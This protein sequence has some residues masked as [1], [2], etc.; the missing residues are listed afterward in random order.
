MNS[1]FIY[2]CETWT[3][4]RYLQKIIRALEMRCLRRLLNI[5]YKD[6]VND[7]EFRRQVTCQLV[8][9]SELL[10]NVT[11]KKLKWFCHVTR[12]DTISKII[13]Q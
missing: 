5:K 10:A 8:P 11:E 6:R 7:V 2:A 1:I 13:L 9:H 3:L 4:S 12:S